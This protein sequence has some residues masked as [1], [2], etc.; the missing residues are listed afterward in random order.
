MCFADGCGTGFVKGRKDP[1]MSKEAW[2]RRFSRLK[3]YNA[4]HGVA[5]HKPLLL[6]VVL[7]MVAAGEIDDVTVALTPEMSFR[8]DTFWRVV[9]HRRTQ[10]PDVR[11]PFYHL[12]TSGI[13]R[14]F[15][16]DGRLSEHPRQTAYVEMDA[17]FLEAARDGEFRNALR[18]ILVAKYFEPLERR[19]LYH[20]MQ[21]QVPSDDEIAQAADLK[22]PDDAADTGRQGR[23][24]L[25]VVAAYN[26]TC[27]LT[28]YRVTTIA[29]G[30]IVDAAHI[31]QFS[32]SRNNDPRNGVA[33]CKN[34]HWLFDAGVWSIDQEYRIVVASACFSESSPDQKPLSAYHGL[35][36]RLP[37]D[38]RMWPDPRHLAWHRKHKFQAS[39]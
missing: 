26:Y 34:A 28:G 5:P 19:A 18:L 36:L 7:E 23:F 1:G 25:D 9:A 30:S 39:I 6:L 24:R 22:M 14:P 10:R 13:W 4:K 12:K 37:A 38:Q 20:L 31:H 3:V 15:T 29:S 33:L 2:Y 8:F 35:Q 16:E 32:N 27:A 17:S 21:L 11:F